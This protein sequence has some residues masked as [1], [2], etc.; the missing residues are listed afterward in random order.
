MDAAIG[1]LELPN[2]SGNGPGAA[3]QLWALYL[4]RNRLRS[5]VEASCEAVINGGC[6]SFRIQL[7]LARHPLDI[8]TPAAWPRHYGPLPWSASALLSRSSERRLRRRLIERWLTGPI[9]S[10]CLEGRS[11]CVCGGADSSADVTP[12]LNSSSQS[13]TERPVGPGKPSETPLPTHSSPS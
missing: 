3:E 2:R 6:V 12:E 5:L 8:R 7:Q 13:F 4:K 9:A 10:S 1:L 11:R